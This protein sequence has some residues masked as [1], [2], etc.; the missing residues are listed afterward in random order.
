[1]AGCVEAAKTRPRH[2]PR[3]PARLGELYAELGHSRRPHSTRLLLGLDPF[4]LAA[5]H[6]RPRL[7]WIGPWAGD[8]MDDDDIN[9]EEFNAV[10]C[11][12]GEA[13]D[14]ARRPS[15]RLTEPMR[16]RAGTTTDGGLDSLDDSPA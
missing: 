11:D 6:A 3:P 16:L 15:Q 8:R 10:A 5:A 7:A 1:M 13:I 2:N 12:N 9:H 4:R 14:A